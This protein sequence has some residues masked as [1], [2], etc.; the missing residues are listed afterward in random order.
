MALTAGP[1]SSVRAGNQAASRRKTRSSCPFVV[2]FSISYGANGTALEKMELKTRAAIGL[3]L[4]RDSGLMLREIAG[5]QGV[6][7]ATVHGRV[8][9]ALRDEWRPFHAGRSEV[10][11]SRS[12][13]GGGEA[14][15]PALS[16]LLRVRRQVGG[17]ADADD[18]GSIA[19]EG[20]DD[21]A[22]TGRLL[23]EGAATTRTEDDVASSCLWYLGN[24]LL[25]RGRTPEAIEV[26]Q[27]LADLPSR[28]GRQSLEILQKIEAAR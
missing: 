9:E 6:S 14:S 28:P 13:P 23:E 21:S 24:L 22:R 11:R 7:T 26:F 17:N 1:N 16:Y 10:V 8:Q 27:D 4:L 2:H 25:R 5:V 18:S 20:G 12:R 19:G 15:P 3:Y